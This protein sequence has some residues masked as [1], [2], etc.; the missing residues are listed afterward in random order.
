MR[1][2]LAA[3][4]IGSAML[5]PACTKTGSS[6]QAI[7]S[8]APAPSAPASSTPGSPS[9]SPT[10]S[11]GVIED[12]RS[13][14]FLKAVANLDTTP[15]LTFDLGY[16]LTGEEANQAAADR[17]DE[18]PVPND[19]YIINDNPKLRTVPIDPAAEILV[20]DWAKCCD[21]YT[22]ITL[23]RFAGYAADP[24]RRFHG[25]SSPHWITVENGVIVKIEEQYLP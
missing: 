22:S 7:A 24:T 10:T 19:Y 17:G 8:P 18:V 9:A 5:G 14:V 23:E 12:G 11:T 1:K 13:F 25:I 15:N 21:S 6:S 20:Y 2:T 4:V 16:F 3:I